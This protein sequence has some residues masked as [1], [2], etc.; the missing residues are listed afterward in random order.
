M[1]HVHLSKWKR[2][3]EKKNSLTFKMTVSCTQDNPACDHRQ[4]DTYNLWHESLTL[5]KLTRTVSDKHFVTMEIM[6]DS[7]YYL[8]T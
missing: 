4:H 6:E 7:S 1:L 2:S 3:R 8:Y 5:V